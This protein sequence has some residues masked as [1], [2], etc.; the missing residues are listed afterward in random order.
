LSLRTEPPSDRKLSREYQKP[1]I[2]TGVT[3]RAA[4]FEVILA[5]GADFGATAGSWRSHGQCPLESRPRIRRSRNELQTACSSRVALSL[6]PV[7]ESRHVY[8]GDHESV[9]Q[10]TLQRARPNGLT[11][12]TEE[13]HFIAAADRPSGGM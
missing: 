9:A 6:K 13:F 10:R 12:L 5:R 1:L 8:P 4:Y 7:I 3:P 11:K 2:A